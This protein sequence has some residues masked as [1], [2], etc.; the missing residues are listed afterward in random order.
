[1]LV[2]AAL[3]LAGC[4]NEEL[5]SEERN[6][7]IAMRLSQAEPF[8]GDPSNKFT[9]DSSAI[10]LGKSLFS[11]AGLSFNGA[12]SCASCH[13]P[14]QQFQDGLPLAVAVGTNTRRTMPL[15]GLAN[16]KWFFWDGR[17]DSLWSQALAPLENPVEHATDRKSVVKHVATKYAAE[18]QKIFGALPVSDTDTDRAF[19][20]VGK[21][22]A[23][24]VATIQ[25]EETRFDRVMQNWANAKAGEDFTKQELRGLKLFVGKGNCVSCHTGPYFTDGF[26]HNTGI[27][28]V[29]GLPPD[30][31]R[32]AVL[33]EA[34]SDA[35]NCLGPYSD[36]KP[37]DCRELR[38]MVTDS[39]EMERAF[40]TPS[41][42][43]VAQRAPYMHAGQFTTLEDALAHYDASPPAPRGH[44]ELRDISLS[45]EDR[46]AII[47]FLKTLD[48]P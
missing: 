48:V 5:T 11:D 45:N 34:K 36:A 17:K 14:D 4:G 40:K 22:L 35:F 6:V 24:Y 13:L 37:E 19:S 30:N 44:S 23:A 16:D 10:A 39:H 47:A 15:A 42:R 12:V 28:E 7:A 32:I 41:L 1:M 20:N 18:Y 26:F 43:G 46:V 8:K 29:V 27:P 38:F 2:A 9:L 21:A 3:H 33:K 25:H 31:G